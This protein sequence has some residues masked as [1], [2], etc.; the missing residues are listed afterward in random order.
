MGGEKEGGRQEEESRG[1]ENL[2]IVVLHTNLKSNYYNSSKC[3]L[4]KR[5]RFQHH[6][7]S[8]FENVFSEILSH[9]SGAKNFR[10]NFGSN[11][12]LTVCAVS[13]WNI[14]TTQSTV[15]LAGNLQEN[16]PDWKCEHPENQGCVQTNSKQRDEY[17]GRIPELS[18]K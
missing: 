4:L 6:S 13:C 1:S 11:I 8:Q 9:L 2:Y 7:S 10:T 17:F 15:R 12:K 14:F 18:G 5:I 3:L 16:Q